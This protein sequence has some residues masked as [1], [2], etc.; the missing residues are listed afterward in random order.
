MP[1]HTAAIFDMDGTLLD[2]MSFWQQLAPEFLK[3][4]KLAVPEYLPEKPV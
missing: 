3:R 4:N 1:K 2:N